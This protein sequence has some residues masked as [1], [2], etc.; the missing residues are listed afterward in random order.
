M[1]GLASEMWL[2]GLVGEAQSAETSC[3]CVGV[4]SCV[5]VG[6]VGR[7]EWLCVVWCAGDATVGIAGGSFL[8]LSAVACEEWRRKAGNEV[9]EMACVY[10]RLLKREWN[11]AH[12]C[13]NQ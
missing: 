2:N 10:K 12:T 5:C 11:T 4:V 8:V 9:R 6:L 13:N 1:N 7:E 3:V